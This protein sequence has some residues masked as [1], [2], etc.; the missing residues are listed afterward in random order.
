MFAFTR[1]ASTS[2]KILSEVALRTRN[3]LIFIKEDAFRSLE[4]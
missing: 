3:A 4:I 2:L 1:G